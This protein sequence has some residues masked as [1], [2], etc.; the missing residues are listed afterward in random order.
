MVRT[1]AASILMNESIANID[2]VHDKY[3]ILS[4]DSK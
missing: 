1:S 2:V 4:P 3:Y